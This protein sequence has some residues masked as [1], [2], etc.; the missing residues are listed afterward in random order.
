MRS[1]RI[2]SALILL[3]FALIAVPGG[4]AQSTPQTG[5]QPTE[6]EA[7]NDQAR[8]NVDQARLEELTRELQDLKAKVEQLE[9]LLSQKETSATT[10][11]QE[12]K[13]QMAKVEESETRVGNQIQSLWDR[14]NDLQAATRSEAPWGTHNFVITGFGSGRYEEI[15]RAHV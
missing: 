6:R 3:A 11:V 15:G 1:A 2:L 9:R 5:L 10:Q 4:L 13:N 12:V 7:K 14:T 8:S